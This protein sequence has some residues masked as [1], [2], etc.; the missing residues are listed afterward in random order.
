MQKFVENGIKYVTDGFIVAELAPFELVEEV[1]EEHEVKLDF[2]FSIQPQKVSPGDKIKVE[3]YVEAP[4]VEGDYRAQLGFK[5]HG[6]S[7]MAPKIGGFTVE[8]DEEQVILTVEDIQK[9]VKQFFSKKAVDRFMPA[10]PKYKEALMKD[11]Q[12]VLDEI[13]IDELKYEQPWHDCDDFAILLGGAFHGNPYT[14]EWKPTVGQALFETWVYWQ[15]DDKTYAHALYAM[16]TR[17][18]ILMIEPQTKK[19]FKVP[20]KWNLMNMKG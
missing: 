17:D 11:V 5:T 18:K 3:G 2:S 1:E 14:P 20:D 9:L 12:A 4:D 7:W 10:D 6:F 8:K 15:E 16:V 19:P 13:R